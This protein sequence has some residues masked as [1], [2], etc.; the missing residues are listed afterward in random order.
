[1]SNSFS[2]SYNENSSKHRDYFQIYDELFK[3]IDRNKIYNILEIGVDNGSGVRALKTHFPNSIIYGLDILE[4]CKQY[5]EENINII[6][7]SQTDEN[8]LKTL[9]NIQFDIIIDDGSHHNSHVFYTFSKLFSSLNSSS[10]GLYIVEDVH[11]SYWPYYGGGHKEP[12]STIEQFKN[13]IDMMHAWCIRDPITCHM[14][15]YKGNAN[16]TKTYY[17]LWVKSI[18]FYENI[19]IVQKRNEPAR[20]SHPK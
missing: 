15:P 3:T 13:I 16:I 18:Q 12:N 9:S 10:V 8:I 11:T 19:I 2:N 1:M 4:R 7:G 6:I 5:E 17:E 14:P 20:C